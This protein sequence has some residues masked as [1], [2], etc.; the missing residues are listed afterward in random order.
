LRLLHLRL[1]IVLTPLLPIFSDTIFPIVES[2]VG[3]G[4]KYEGYKPVF[5]GDN[6]GPHID[7]A[8]LAGIKGHCETK[9]WYWEPQA[10][11]MPHMNVLDL[12][13][14]PC[15]SKRRSPGAAGG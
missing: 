3:P 11:Q 15:M 10:S 12:S 14:F 4:G 13:V 8:Y 5:Q 1:L 2:L 6:A 9:G 7:A